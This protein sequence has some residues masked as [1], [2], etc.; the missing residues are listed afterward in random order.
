MQ[1]LIPLLGTI[2]QRH[3]EWFE[4]QGR[5]G[6][7]ADLSEENLEGADFEGAALIEANFQ[8]ARLHKANFQRADLRGANLHD[9]DLTQ[10]QFQDCNLRH[11]DT[12]N[13]FLFRRSFLILVFLQKL[14]G[15]LAVIGKYTAT[16]F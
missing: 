4:S 6:V 10:A 12:D 8:G 2:L 3:K 15:L 1:S 14:S 5:A 11:S 16:A 9:A 7:F 13:R